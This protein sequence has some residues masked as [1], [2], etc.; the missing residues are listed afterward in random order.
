MIAL[1][2]KFLAISGH[3]IAFKNPALPF[4]VLYWILACLL[5]RHERQGIPQVCF[6]GTYVVFSKQ[7]GI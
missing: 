4:L 5:V 7:F 6:Q 1:D 3:L 2:T